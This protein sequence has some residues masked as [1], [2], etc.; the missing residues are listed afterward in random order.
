MG[1][2]VYQDQDMV[3]VPGSGEGTIRATA[4]PVTVTGAAE[5]QMSLQ[6][7]PRTDQAQQSTR[8]AVQE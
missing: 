5:Q 8:I 3:I 7:G 1:H 2:S 6:A 4:A